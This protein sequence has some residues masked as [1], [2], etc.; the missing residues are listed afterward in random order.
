MNVYAILMRLRALS[1]STLYN[2]CPRCHQGKVFSHNNPYSG[3][4]GFH[5]EKNC[6]HCG[7]IYEKEPGYFFGAM[8]VSY[9]LM[10]GWLVC[11]F[12]INENAIHADVFPF[13]AFMLISTMLF[14]P[15]TFRWS[16]IIW[17]NFFIKY[18]PKR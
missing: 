10:T 11:C 8:Y 4:K 18:D 1:S 15:L 12:L 3:S 7:E 6:S 9:A 13:L 5:M 14:L 17:L 2:R 16:R